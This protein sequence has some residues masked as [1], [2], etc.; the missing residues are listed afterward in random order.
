MDIQNFINDFKKAMPGFSIIYIEFIDKEVL[1]KV[2]F[3]ILNIEENV[4]YDPDINIF[5]NN[6][7][8]VIKEQVLNMIKYHEGMALSLRKLLIGDF[9]VE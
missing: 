2:K 7:N 4:I 1:A 5:I 9:H 3:D 8:I 6:V